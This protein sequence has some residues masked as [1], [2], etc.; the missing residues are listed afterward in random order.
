M[1]FLCR[2]GVGY[3]SWKSLLDNKQKHMPF[4]AYGELRT[5]LPPLPE[6]KARHFSVGLSG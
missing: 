5:D 6:L 3:G 4:E 2:W 1:F